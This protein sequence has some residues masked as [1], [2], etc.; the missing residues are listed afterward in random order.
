MRSGPATTNELDQCQ[1]RHCAHLHDRRFGLPRKRLES[2][3]VTSFPAM[4][5]PPERGSVDPDPAIAAVDAMVSRV[6]L[7]RAGRPI[8]V[9][10]M[11]LFLAS[12]EASYCTGMEFV[13]DGGST[14]G[15]PVG[16]TA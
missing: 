13:V 8:E 14:T 7:R 12:D 15:S 1:H 11:A 16:R 10:R 6:P 5:E 3:G 4:A 2:F 9:A